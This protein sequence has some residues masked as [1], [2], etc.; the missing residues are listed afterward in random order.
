[1]VLCGIATC[2]LP[3]GGANYMIMGIY[4]GVFGFFGGAFA[5]LFSVVVA[6]LFG[7]SNL[8]R[9]LGMAV[10]SWGVGGLVGAPASGA[11]FDATGSYTIAWIICGCLW[12]GGGSMVAFLHFVDQWYPDRCKRPPP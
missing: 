1:M 10:T 12:M 6:E 7:L 9:A 4:A 8:P 3:V 2:L 11:I 5:G